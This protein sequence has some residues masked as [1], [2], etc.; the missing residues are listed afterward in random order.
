[1]NYVRNHVQIW[2]VFK[3]DIIISGYDMMDHW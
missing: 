1:M 2:N 3:P